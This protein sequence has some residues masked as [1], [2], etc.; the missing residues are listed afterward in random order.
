MTRLV[1]GVLRRISVQEP[2]QVG[3][4]RYIKSYTF[5]QLPNG[6]YEEEKGA[7]SMNQDML[8]KKIF[9]K[10]ARSITLILLTVPQVPST[11]AQVPPSAV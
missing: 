6:K 9:L 7:D 1:L 11:T 8:E 4:S 2:T 10:K 5:I 3:S